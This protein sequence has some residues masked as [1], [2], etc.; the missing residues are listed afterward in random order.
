MFSYVDAPK[1][2]PFYL[3]VIH[4]RVYEG[5]NIFVYLGLVCFVEHFVAGAGVEFQGD[6]FSVLPVE[7]QGC[8]GAL[9]PRWQA[10]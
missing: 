8:F 7:R 9:P 4:Y 1:N 6:V 3:Y 2:T 10:V 5:K